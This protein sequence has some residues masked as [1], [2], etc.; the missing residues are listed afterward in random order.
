MKNNNA[1]TNSFPFLVALIIGILGGLILITVIAALV[2]TYIAKK[3]KRESTLSFKPKAK[4]HVCPYD[5]RCGLPDCAEVTFAL[6]NVAA[7]KTDE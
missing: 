1:G 3:K 5:Q 6:D 4:D 2:L 7:C